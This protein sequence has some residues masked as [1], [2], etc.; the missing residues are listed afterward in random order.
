MFTYTMDIS[1]TSLPGSLTNRIALTISSITNP[2]WGYTRTV[3]TTD[4]AWDE[5]PSTAQSVFN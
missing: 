1:D 2:N 5:N 3:S 4:R